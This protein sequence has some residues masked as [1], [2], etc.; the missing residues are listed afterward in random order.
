MPANVTESPR[1]REHPESHKA[2]DPVV[3][4]PEHTPTP[5]PTGQRAAGTRGLWLAIYFIAALVAALAGVLI[6]RAVNATGIETATAGGG[7]FLAVMALAMAI[8]RYLKE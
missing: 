2:P 1:D 8:D 6:A 4:L 7:T 3:H 5:R